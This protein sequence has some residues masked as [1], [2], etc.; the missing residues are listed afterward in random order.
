MTNIVRRTGTSQ[1]EVFLEIVEAS[2]SNGIAVKVLRQKL[3][4]C[5]DVVP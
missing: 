1:I 3:L 2:Q 5:V 4:V